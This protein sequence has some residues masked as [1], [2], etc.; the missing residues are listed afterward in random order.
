MNKHLFVIFLTAFSCNVMAMDHPG[1]Q[2]FLR[3]GASSPDQG[4]VFHGAGEPD[5]VI[6]ACGLEMTVKDLAS[7]ASSSP[8]LERKV[9]AILSESGQNKHQQ[10]QAIVALFDAS[11]KPQA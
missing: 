7:S 8:E 1:S 2:Y 5:M 9:L 6:L 10:A 11:K 3:V 4:Q